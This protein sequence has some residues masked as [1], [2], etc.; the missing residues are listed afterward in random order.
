MLHTTYTQGS[1]VDSRLF[2]VMTQTTNLTPGLF[3]CHNL[4]CRCPNGSCEPILDIYI[5]IG[6]WWYIK[7]SFMQGVLAF[8][9]ILWMF[10]SPLRLQLA[11]WELTWE[12]DSS[13]SHS[14]TLLLARIFANLCLGCEP[15]AKVVTLMKNVMIEKHY[16]YFFIKR[17]L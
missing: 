14:L 11:K 2:V 5:S 7:N 9:I 12:C 13:F 3:L 15:K 8:V 16:N 6:F 10:K 17:K 4:C 1:W